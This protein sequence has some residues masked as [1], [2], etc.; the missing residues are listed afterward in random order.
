MNCRKWQIG[1]Y[2]I[3]TKILGFQNLFEEMMQNLELDVSADRGTAR[4]NYEP[5]SAT[6]RST[7]N[8]FPT[9]DQ[10]L[11]GFE[12]QPGLK[13]SNTPGFYGD[14]TRHIL[15]Y[16][17]SSVRSVLVPFTDKDITVCNSIGIWFHHLAFLVYALC[18]MILLAYTSFGDGSM[19]GGSACSDDN[20]NQN[21]DVCKLD[22]VL[23]DAKSDFRWLIAFVLAG[24]VGISVTQWAVRRQNYAS[25]C[26][27][28]IIHLFICLNYKYYFTYQVLTICRCSQQEMRGI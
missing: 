7:P 5:K 10:F 27:N 17:P 2:I 8:Q 15:T 3:A 24:Y 28:K 4:L 19:G 20:T 12:R 11:F 16:D 21:L 14:N 25:L 13:E 6:V 26:G 9:D 22:E 18:L 1:V 23:T